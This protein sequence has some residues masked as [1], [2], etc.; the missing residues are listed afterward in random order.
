MYGSGSPFEIPV[1][2]SMDGQTAT[3][4]NDLRWHG[5]SG[6]NS[7]P[8]RNLAGECSN[9]ISVLSQ[10]IETL[11][12]EHREDHDR[13]RHIRS[14]TVSIGT[15]SSLLNMLEQEKQGQGQPSLFEDGQGITYRS[16]R[17]CELEQWFSIK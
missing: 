10:K 17:S 12:R 7:L 5:G 11:C 8:D 2:D 9:L 15:L 16:V 6:G 3:R 13:V 4:N 1:I 14:L